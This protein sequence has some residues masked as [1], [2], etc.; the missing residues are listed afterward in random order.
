[1]GRRSRSAVTETVTETMTQS[2]EGPLV[3]SAEAALRPAYT[4]TSI[5][6]PAFNEEEGIEGVV[7]RLAGITL[8]QGEVEILVVDDGSTDGTREVLERLSAEFG[9][10]RVIEKPRNEG[11]GAALLTGFSAAKHNVVVITDA[12]GTYPEDRIGELVEIVKEGADMAI[13]SRTG[14]DVHIPLIRRPAKAFLR[15]LA[16]FLAEFPIP[17]LNSGL[18]AFRR[19]FVLAYQVTLDQQRTALAACPTPTRTS[20]VTLED[21]RKAIEDAKMIHNLS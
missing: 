7:R 18:R 15:K 20:R 6:V 19:D 10:L 12:D 14:T 13:G 21:A 2:I 3:E 11:Y 17:D 8:G 9:S 1:M 16:S 5:V 4:G